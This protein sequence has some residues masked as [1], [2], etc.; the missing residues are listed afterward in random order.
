MQKISACLFKAL[1]SMAALALLLTSCKED[2]QTIIPSVSLDRS[3]LY[4][5]TPSTTEEVTFWYERAVGITMT[6]A[7]K[8]WDVTY[9]FAA[10]KIWVTSPAADD[11]TAEQSGTITL[12]LYSETYNSTQFEIFV[13]TLYPQSLADRRSNC[14][15]LTEAGKSYS[16]PVT[17]RGESDE[18]ID[19]KS[20]KLLWQDRINLIAHVQMMDLEQVSFFVEADSKG[21]IIPGNALLGGYDAEG[22]LLWTWHLWVTSTEPQAVGRYMDRNLG[23][24]GVK[25]STQ[26][27]ILRSYGTYYQWG[28]LTPFAGPKYYNCASSKSADLYLENGSNYV[29]IAYEEAEADTATTEYALQHPLLYLLSDQMLACDWNATHPTD[30]W[31][32]D[33]KT[34]YDPCPKGWR[35]ADNFDDLEFAGNPTDDLSLLEA[36]FGWELTDGENILFFPGCGRR[37]WLQGLITNVNT[38][39]TP[40]PWIGYY[41]TATTEPEHLARALSFSLDTE[42]PSDSEFDRALAS[43]RANGMQVR[44]IKE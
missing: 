17:F 26:E 12:Y 20:V 36:Q 18:R 1:F 25:H 14:Y 19:V 24:D 9:D 13:S 33:H 42:N 37:S 28:R 7:P 2:D 31:S 23:A 10:G 40:K 6:G 39:E 15:L 8:G 11:Q 34:L 41:W 3:A 38:A 30:L 27:E 32:P 4:I 44:C 16:F 22:N 21:N 29:Y 35:V 43:P 5:A